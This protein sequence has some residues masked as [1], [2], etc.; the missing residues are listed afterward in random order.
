MGCPSDLAAMWR[1]YRIKLIRDQLVF[2]CAD[3]PR[4]VQLSFPA[5]AEGKSIAD[6]IGAAFDAIL[7]TRWRGPD[8]DKFYGKWRQSGSDLDPRVQIMTPWSF[9]DDSTSPINIFGA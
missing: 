9:V 3:M 1:D 6:S 8:D 4:W 7:T 2:V 5:L